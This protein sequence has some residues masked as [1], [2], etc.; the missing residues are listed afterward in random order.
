MTTVSI[1]NAILQLYALQ[2]AGVRNVTIKVQV[3]NSNRPAEGTICRQI[4]DH[5]DEEVAA[6]RPVSSKEI[7]LWGERLGFNWHTIHRQRRLWAGIPNA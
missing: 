6:G 5:C 1:E 2:D 3:Q 7:N 4:W